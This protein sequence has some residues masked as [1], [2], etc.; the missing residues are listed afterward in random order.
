M[1]AGSCC[2]ASGG[3]SLSCTSI[4]SAVWFPSSWGDVFQGICWHVACSWWMYAV[5]LPV[6]SV[7]WSPGA[8]SLGTAYLIITRPDS[9][10]LPHSWTHR[11]EREQLTFKSYFQDIMGD[12]VTFTKVTAFSDT[13][14][15]ING[16]CLPL[17]VLKMAAL[18]VLLPALCLAPPF[19][20]TFSCL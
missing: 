8:G 13:Y 19:I 20:G 10:V 9:D 18:S 16:R 17:A 14:F 15:C 7:R 12:E 5:R 11:A 6:P 1:Y 4:S 3:C 2:L